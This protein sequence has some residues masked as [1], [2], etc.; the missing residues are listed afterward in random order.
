MSGRARAVVVLLRRPPAHPRTAQGLRAAVGYLTAGLGV[1]VLLAGPAAALLDGA[2]EGPL[3]R[4]LD[5]LRALGR[6]VRVFADGDVA[7]L[8]AAH[9]V[10]VW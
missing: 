9:A 2:V 5:T 7:A 6:G 1:T 3:R 4:H 10:V 8:G